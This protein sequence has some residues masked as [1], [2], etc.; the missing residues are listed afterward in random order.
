MKKKTFAG[1]F[2]C[3]I[4]VIAVVSITMLLEYHR[5]T[6][7]DKTV[8]VQIPKGA[9]EKR[10]AEILKENGVID[11][12]ITFRLKMKTSPYRGKLNYGK[13]ELN[14]KMS[15]DDAIETLAKP[16][17]FEKG[18]TLTIP[19]GYSA[20]KIAVLCEKKGLCTAEEFLRELS[21]EK[22][23]HD[24]IKD[25]PEKDGIKYKLQGYLFPSTYNFNKNAGASKII[26]TLLSEFQLQYNKVKD[27]LPAGMTM[28]EAVNRAALIEREAK[29]DSEREMISGVIQ[30]RLDIDMILQIDAS[31]VY[32]ISD[33]IYDV[34][35]VL[36]KDLE[37]DS[38]Y[39]TYKYKGLPIGPICN[40][41]L[42]SL[43][44]AMN[45]TEHNYLYYH[46]DT[47]KN[48]GSHIF[49]ETF[50]QHTK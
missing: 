32:A 42:E 48:D 10:I 2:L 23:N 12:E 35:R 50:S 47:T 40:P 30:N 22:F 46:T 20:E 33:G 26:N 16:G 39:N 25:I 6:S 11:Y 1:L 17:E 36:Y 3:I 24:F 44:A 7:S 14:K 37:T 15:I 18:I 19:E 27:M 13:F 8:T 31:V 45:P 43:R 9:S 4:I 41:G 28:A 21:E 5:T 34:D 38:P 49:S 29:L